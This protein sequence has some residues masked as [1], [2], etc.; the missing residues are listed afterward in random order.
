MASLFPPSGPAE[1][2]PAV[3]GV[4]AGDHGKMT[5]FVLDLTQS[6]SFRVFTLANPYR[7]VVDLPELDWTAE[8]VLAKPVGFVQGWRHGLF[9]PG[10]ARIVIDLNRPATIKD[11][12]LLPPRDGANWR[13]VLDLEKAGEEAFLRTQ[14]APREV[15]EALSAVV[16]I[17]MPLADPVRPGRDR[18]PVIVIDAG[19]GG[20][21]PGAVGVS[22][23]YEKELTLAMAKEVKKAL[24][25]AGRYEVV[26]TRDRDIF[27]A[28]RERV[29][30][31]RS[32]GGDLFISLHADAI[33]NHK[34]RG[35]SI[36]TL[37]EKS[38]D[39]EAAAL[40]EKENKSDLIAGMDFSNESPEVTSILID[41]A[42]RETMNLSAVFASDAVN[43]LGRETDLLRN[44]HRFAGFAVLKAPDVPSILIELGYL[45]NRDEEK[46]LRN[47]AYRAKLAG[48][49]ARS[50]ER[51]FRHIQRAQRP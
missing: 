32:A 14:G 26:L 44:T 31:A 43:E 29:D 24:D 30:L 38:S 35:L 40:A 11:A 49:L 6:V 15:G 33:D 22:G 34:I 1:A 51:Y 10:N 47:A 45:S 5:R 3:T 13:F 20:V 23:I 37:S 25:A 18:K 21:D 17:S 12:F 2:R 36:Y 41:L 8:R 42:Q 48:A 4:R 46:L 28:L 39:A 19:H 7:V 9:R 50:I 27:L 16:P